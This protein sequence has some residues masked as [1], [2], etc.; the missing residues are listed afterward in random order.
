MNLLAERERV[1]ADK[2]LYHRL[3][4]PQ[5]RFFAKSFDMIVS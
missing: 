2:Y 3:K 1:A 5:K 4:L